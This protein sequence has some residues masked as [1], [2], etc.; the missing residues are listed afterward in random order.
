MQVFQ[1][2][3]FILRKFVTWREKR[4]YKK[5]IY[6]YNSKRLLKKKHSQKTPRSYGKKFKR[7]RGLKFRRRRKHSRKL[8]KKAK[9]KTYRKRLKRFNFLYQRKN[10]KYLYEFIQN[11]KRDA[12]LFK[13]LLKPFP[14]ESKERREIVEKGN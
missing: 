10:K 13:S 12:K 5:R 2:D 6:L 4:L 3:Y 11:V 14:K 7:R 9:K 8:R 1:D